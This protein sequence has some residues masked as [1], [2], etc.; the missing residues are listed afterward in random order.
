VA[1]IAAGVLINTAG[2]L[3]SQA[4]STG[5]ES[6][7][8]VANNLDVTLVNGTTATTSS[9]GIQ[10]VNVTVQLAPGADPINLGDTTNELYPEGATRSE[11]DAA[12]WDSTTIEEGESA[13]LEIPNT[14]FGGSV[15]GGDGLPAGNEAQLVITTADGSQVTTTFAAPDTITTSG[16]DV[17]LG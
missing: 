13:N 7:A 3:Q 2:F 8:Q 17:I 15:G 11:V 6:T 1:A 14:D 12:N 9:E 16:E 10:N 4:E 5:Q